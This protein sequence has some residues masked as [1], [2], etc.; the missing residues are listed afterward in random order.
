MSPYSTAA[1]G[2]KDSQ[3]VMLI[4][5]L[6][7]TTTPPFAVPSTTITGEPGGGKLLVVDGPL[8][9]QPTSVPATPAKSN[10][11]PA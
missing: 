2:G 3:F 6:S 4:V 5:K 7:G 1:K 9:V 8:L 10:T 11:I